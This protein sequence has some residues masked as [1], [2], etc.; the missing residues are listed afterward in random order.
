MSLLFISYRRDDSAP[1]AVSIAQRLEKHFEIF[2]DV[3]NLR[4]GDSFPQILSDK[5]TQCHALVA[6]IGPA[7]LEVRDNDGTRRLDNPDDWV[8]LELEAALK[9]GIPIIPLL[10]F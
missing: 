6:V 4:I 10:V 7:W 2:I 8:R 9:R 5:L 1:Y 3:E